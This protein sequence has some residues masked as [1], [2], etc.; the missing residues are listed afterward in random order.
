MKKTLHFRVHTPNL[1][2]EI[3]ENALPK[4]M[5]VLFVPL[6]QLRTLLGQVAQRCT[7]LHDPVLDR[8][9]FD[10]TLYDLPVP[11]SKEYGQLMR[12]VYQAEKKYLK[13]QK[14]TNSTARV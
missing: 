11:T 10:M 2:E 7:E 9:M 14:A 5:G 13:G 12:K 1:L 8:L 4:S 3:V 6:N